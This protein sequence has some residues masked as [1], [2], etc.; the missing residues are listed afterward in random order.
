[1]IDSHAH[2][3]DERFAG[4]VDEVLARAHE[5]GVDS[6][7]CVA[8]DVEGSRAALALAERHAGL[9]A[10]V[11]VH[12]HS[13]AGATPEAIAELRAL[14]AHPRAVAIGEMGL[15]FHYDFAPR[16]AQHEAF[17]R[18]IELA[19]EL[20]LPVVV[21]A[22]EADGDLVALLREAGRGSRGVLHSFS[23][24]RELLE[25]ALDL[26][27]YASFSGMITF[28]NYAQTE[29]LRLVPLDRLLVE[30]DSPYLAPV[31]NRGKRNEP[32]YVALVARRA[33]ELRGE[34]PEVLAEAAARNTR[35]LFGLG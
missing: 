29:L 33:A 34:E 22:R 6:V 10:T 14:A 25:T 35:T 20:D 18:Q 7:I 5:A 9:F 27:W 16:E 15:D 26:G 2:L 21:H 32:A 1:M 17:L 11:G 28:K 13:A 23:S 30:T 3:T 12:P 31:P 8:T 4:E 19:R 24:G